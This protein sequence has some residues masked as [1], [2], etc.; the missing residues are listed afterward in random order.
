[1]NNEEV[2]DAWCPAASRWSTWAK[3]VLFTSL[4]P[5]NDD[6]SLR[7]KWQSLDVTWAPRRGN[8][9]AIILDLP[10]TESILYAA[11]L[12]AIGYQPVP[13]F[14]CCA[15][16][17]HEVLPTDGLREYL[18][19]AAADL[20]TGQLAPD[21]PPVFLLDSNRLTGSHPPHPGLFDNR[22]MTFPQDFPSGRFLKDAGIG[23]IILARD[24]TGPPE[25]DL[26]QVLMRWQEVEVRLLQ[27][28]V[29]HPGEPQLL[30]VAP[31]PRYRWF[32]Q[33]T[34]ALLGFMQNSAGGFGSV[35]PE[36]GGAG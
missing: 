31:P 11:A 9:T 23:K 4:L 5:L 14:N 17:A 28:D 15:A 13:L 25:L 32:F 35:I 3:P 20:R 21:A 7:D 8:D 2:F 12:F 6:S 34:L 29:A 27:T 36:P 33:R 22:W 24:K 18:V 30:Q 1:M 10:G 19:R 26:A 16:A